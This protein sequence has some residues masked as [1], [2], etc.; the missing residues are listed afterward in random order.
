MKTKRWF[1]PCGIP[2][3]MGLL[4]TV[5]GCSPGGKVIRAEHGELTFTSFVDGSEQTMQVPPDSSITLDGEPAALEDIEEGDKVS[6][7]VDDRNGE[8]VATSV[9]AQSPPAEEEP[10]VEPSDPDYPVEDEPLFDP[11]GP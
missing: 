4:L 1:G 9:I 5:G 8:K 3:A 11:I 10:S 7:E 6:V 2:L